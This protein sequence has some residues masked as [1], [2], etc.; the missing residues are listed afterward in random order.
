M[1]QKHMILS[2]QLFCLFFVSHLIQTITNSPGLHTRDN[3]QN[4]ILGAPIALAATVLATTPMLVL[5]HRHPQLNVLDLTYYRL[6]KYAGVVVGALYAVFFLYAPSL[7]VARYNLYIQTTML[8]QASVILLSVAV[9]FTACYGAFMG[10]E[11]L[12]RASGL[13]F[14]AVLVSLVFIF[15]ALTPELDSRNF[16]PFGQDGIGAVLEEAATI[17]SGL[18]EIATLAI[19]LP[20]AKRKHVKRNFFLWALAET[21]TIALVA[22]FVVGVLGTYTE[23]QMYP[24]YTISTIARVGSLQRLDALYA[25]IWTAGLFVKVAFFLI[26]L[27]LCLTRIKNERAGRV[28]LVVGAAVI[29]AASVLL[30]DRPEYISFLATRETSLLLAA[31]FFLCI[32]LLVLVVDLIRGRKDPRL[33]AAQRKS[34]ANGA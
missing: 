15:A 13:I 11:A 31:V 12:A 16:A 24:F 7:A 30:T 29:L 33:S 2:G 27:S 22:F 32:P 3:M 9:V 26:A 5:N 1:N 21:V 25:A 34:D 19:V 14:A 23:M 17:V 20:F 8:P 10:I 4:I 6:G 18:L 28:G